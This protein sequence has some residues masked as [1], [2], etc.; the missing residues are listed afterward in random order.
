MVEYPMVVSRL[1]PDDGGGYLV[2]VPDLPGCVS[3][4]ETTEEALS[5][6]RDAVCEW[7]AAAEEMGR[8]IPEPGA[9]QRYSGKWLQRVPKSL[10]MR[11][12]AQAKRDGVSLNALATSLLAEGLG[13]KKASA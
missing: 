5:N 9:S 3:D 8:L 7:I 11:L 6:A 13:R 10:H 1:K 2:E 12:A 4:G